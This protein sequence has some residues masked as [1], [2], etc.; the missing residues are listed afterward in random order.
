MGFETVPG[1][2][3]YDQNSATSTIARSPLVN[4]LGLN[5]IKIK[6]DYEIQGEVEPNGL[7]ESKWT[8]YDYMSVVYSFDGTTFFE[9]TPQEGFGHFASP[10]IRSGT[11]EGTLPSYF[12]NKKFYIGFRW[13]NDALVGTLLSVRIDNL[14]LDG[15][16]R[17]IENDLNHNAG[18]QL[19][20]GQQVYFYSV[21]DGQ[22][23]GNI[24]NTSTKGFGCTNL[25]IAKAGS[26][27]STLD[28][29]SA[30]KHI[31][32]DKTIRVETAVSQSKASTTITLYYTEE[33][34]KTLWEATKTPPSKFYI[35]QVNASGLG[36]ASG[37][38]TQK[39]AVSYSEIAG[40]GGSFSV[41][42]SNKLGG[43]FYIIGVPVSTKTSGGG[44]K[45]QSAPNERVEEVMPGL[46]IGSIYPNPAAHNA[47]VNIST[48][49]T[50]KLIMEY[51]T[52]GGQLLKV[53]QQQVA[54]GT[55]RIEL[56]LQSVMRGMYMIRF[57]DEN[58]NLLD[59]KTFIK[60]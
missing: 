49:E 21:Q 35:Y 2:G 26:G 7:D 43:S 17:K 39:F 19:N 32:A 33:Q 38:N 6:F 23:L 3:Y 27:T 58:G 53:Q 8:K 24:N 16:P 15:A 54:P 34:I 12:N 9:L 31:V 20:A 40:V 48:S 50:K 10:E 36:S 5:S 56:R 57:R 46:R 29:G 28:L 13:Y 59:T 41:T 11:F 42:V 52:L 25:S 60:Q 45:G 18:E 44:G 37:T 1:P 14:T 22:I 4:G 47:F 30:G 51:V 55:N